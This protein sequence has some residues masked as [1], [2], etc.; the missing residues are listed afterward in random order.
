MDRAERWWQRG[1]I[2]Q[3]YP[4]SFQDT[5]GDGTGDLT[6]IQSRL[7]YLDWLG[8]D[9][10]WLG[11]IYP[12]PMTDFGYDIADFTGVNQRFGSLADLDALIGALHERGMRLIL[13]FVPNHTSDQH[14][15]FAESRSSRDNPRRDW[16]IWADPGALGGPPNNW[17]SRFGG[18]AWQW[19]AATEQYYY[20]AFLPEQPD[21]NWR[22]PEVRAAMADVLRFWIARGVDGFR[23]DSAAVLAEDACRRDD[24][25]NPDADLDTPPPDRLTRIYTNY[26]PEVLG[27]LAEL[28]AV[29]DDEG[30]QV[31][32]GEVDASD[33]RIADFYG[34]CDRPIVH[35]PLNYRLHDTAWKASALAGMI[36]TYLGLLPAHAWPCWVLGSH[37][38]PRI[39]SV[40]GAR[41]VRIAAML[42][43]TLPGTPIFYA[44]DELGMRSVPIPSGQARDPFERELPG[45]GLNRDPERTPMQWDTGAEAGFTTHTPWLPVADDF[46]QHNVAVE[47]A[48]D[49]SLLNLYRRL[50]RLRHEQPALIDGRYTLV[51]A[52]DDV[53]V[54]SRGQ[55]DQRLMVLLNLGE[56]P[57]SWRWPQVQPG[58]VLLSTEHDRAEAPTATRL[59][60]RPGEGLIVKL[61]A[62]PDG[63]TRDR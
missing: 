46:Q 20:H 9:G 19:D 57:R 4:L 61:A 2:Y 6:G 15:W 33:E 56:Q 25:R 48:D 52:D 32:L 11:P 45:Y 7:D 51:S 14:P 18:S 28:R 43:T 8:V 29:V 41:H 37:D 35:L 13:D 40:T 21:L 23:I 5:D 27:W 59:E 50:I 58:R 26:R 62:D 30:G 24:P 1:V 42:L 53:L 54:Y 63:S 36:D 10:V 38:K 39:A 31:L 49:R 16:Y 47:R 55:D 17:L 3:I 22:N 44:G 34:D 12:S 60:L